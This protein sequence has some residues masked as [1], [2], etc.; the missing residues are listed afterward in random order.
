MY[1]TQFL[2]HF[3]S[4]SLSL[5]LLS[6]FSPPV[7]L[8]FSFCVEVYISPFDFF[9]LCLSICEFLFPFSFLILYLSFLYLSLYFYLTIEGRKKRRRIVSK[10]EANQHFCTFKKSAGPGLWKKLVLHI[11]NPELKKVLGLDYLHLLCVQEVV[12]HLI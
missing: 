2:Y 9:C 3:G 5:F 12:T 4:T 10:S 7:S 1:S 6:I 8:F 11:F